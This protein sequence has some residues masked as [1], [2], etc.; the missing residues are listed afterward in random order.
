MKHFVTDGSAAEALKQIHD[1]GYAH[2]YEADPR[3][4]H[5][6]GASFSSKTGT[7]EEWKVED[8]VVTG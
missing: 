7:I 8:E 6:I 4:K 3:T 5:I 1:R 2:A